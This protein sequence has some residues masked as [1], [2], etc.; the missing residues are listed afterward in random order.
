MVELEKRGPRLLL[1]PP[2]HQGRAAVVLPPWARTPDMVQRSR[3][4]VIYGW[5]VSTAM[6]YGW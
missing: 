1:H 5:R 3:N 2:S 6:Y 4:K